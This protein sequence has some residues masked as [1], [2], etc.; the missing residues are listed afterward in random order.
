[1]R[2]SKWKMEWVLGLVTG[3]RGEASR[4]NL[5]SWISGK[6]SS[7]HHLNFSMPKTASIFKKLLGNGISDSIDSAQLLF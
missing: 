4:Q 3:E 1:M 7:T 6:G 5:L 2:S